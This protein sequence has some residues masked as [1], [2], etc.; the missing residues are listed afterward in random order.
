M[1]RCQQDARGGGGISGGFLFLSFKAAQREDAQS[2]RMEFLSQIGMGCVAQ[3]LPIFVARVPWGI[4]PSSFHSLDTDPA[5]LF[6]ARRLVCAR[7]HEWLHPQR[8]A[9]VRLERTVACW[10]TRLGFLSSNIT[11]GL[12]ASVVGDAG[13]HRERALVYCGAYQ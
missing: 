13:R 5:R 3:S 8:P 10:D 12:Q 11:R 4:A 9:T 6:A 1:G 2:I 7:A